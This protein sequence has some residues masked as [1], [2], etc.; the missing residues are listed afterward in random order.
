MR[1]R[2][3]DEQRAELV[4]LVLDEAMPQRRAAARLRVAESTAHHWVR[5]AAAARQR[6]AGSLRRDDEPA[7]PTFARLVRASPP[8][9]LLLRVG[10][11]SLE[12]SPGFDVELLRQVVA[13]LTEEAA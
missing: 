3:T 1:R 10:P 5:R 12:V 4:R 7:P 11:V 13:A 6:T 8:A 2:Y 9:A